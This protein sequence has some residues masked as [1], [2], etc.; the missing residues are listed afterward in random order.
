MGLSIVP[1]PGSILL[2]AMGVAAIG[3]RTTRRVKRKRVSVDGA[4]SEEF[5]QW[6]IS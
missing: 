4:E 2:L 3:L 6:R 1:E 5:E